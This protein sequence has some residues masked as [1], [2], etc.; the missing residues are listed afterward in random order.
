MKAETTLTAIDLSSTPSGRWIADLRRDY[1]ST[2]GQA[3]VT[4]VCLTLVGIL[5]WSFVSW[6]F[7]HSVWTG[8]PEDCHK[9]SGAC[10]AVVTDRYRLILFGLYPYEE[11]WRSA[12][13]CLA[14][15]AT[16]ILSCIPLFWSAKLLPVIWLVGY[17]TFYYLMRGG[18]LGLPVVLE[19]QWGGLA[20]TTFVFSSTVVIGMPL[21]IILALLRRS[22]LPVISS[23]TA[24]FIDGVRSLPL[25][26]ILFTAAIILPFALPSFLVGDKLYRVI[27]GAAVFFAVY[28]AE[29]IRSGIQSLP[30]GQEEAAVA[31]GLNYWQTISRIILPQAF[32]LALPP[33]INQV[34][35]AFMET[36]LIV[37][38]GFFEVTASGNA[39]FSAGGWNT[40]Y[41]EVY[42][43][44]ALIYFTFTF[45]L[46][47]YGAYL[48]RSL[49]TSSR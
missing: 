26:S 30:T 41:A 25:L 35:I 43:F 17:G 31:L 1:F 40:F 18:I 3:L 6:A 23:V 4:L 7:L 10:W 42:F 16:V 14:I 47:R 12:L 13:A 2:P 44:V 34:V 33:T 21:A 22:K 49:K 24:L 37:I 5:V 19:T 28:Q 27:L 45:S 15:L 48:E 38:L 39:S 32:R 8:T 46:S 11:Q 36:S 29:I 20:L 9:A